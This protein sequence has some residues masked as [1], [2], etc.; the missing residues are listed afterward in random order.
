MTRYRIIIHVKFPRLYKYSR[1]L[2]DK[3]VNEE[4][5]NFLY[6]AKKHRKLKNDKGALISLILYN[7]YWNISIDI[8]QSTK[9]GNRVDV[10]CVCIYLKKKIIC[11]SVYARNGKEV[12][13]WS[14]TRTFLMM[15]KKYV[16]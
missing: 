10:T 1:K 4:R 15:F 16:C 8:Q 6:F 5:L 14:Y 7:I 13:N 3:S 9:Q 11:S 2:R 12:I